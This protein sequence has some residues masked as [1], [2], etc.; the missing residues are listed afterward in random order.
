MKDFLPIQLRFQAHILLILIT[1]TLLPLFLGAFT[2]VNAQSVTEEVE[3]LSIPPQEAYFI[4]DRTQ[5]PFN[6]NEPT[7][8]PDEKLDDNNIPPMYTPNEVEENTDTPPTN[9]DEFN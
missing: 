7:S 3:V 2:Q 9:A 1:L 8:Y 4:E 5:E 6:S